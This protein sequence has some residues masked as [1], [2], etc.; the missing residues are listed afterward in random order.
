MAATKFAPGSTVCFLGDSITQ[1][2]GWI[3]RIYEH[4]RRE[5]IGCRIY[6]CG[7]GGDTA[8]HA[9]WRLEETVFCYAPT[10]V[11]VAFGM[12][13]CA[14]GVFKN[15]PLTEKWVIYRRRRQ[16]NC[17]HYLRLI[18]QRCLERNIAV[19]LCTPTLPDALTNLEQ[20]LY[21]GAA[22]ALQEIAVR[23]RALAEELGVGCA[24]ITTPF[25]RQ[26]LRFWKQDKT[27][28]GP[29]RVHPLPEGHEFM[30]KA[31]LQAQGFPMTLP[32][33]WAELE[34]LVAIPHDP[35]EEKR[36]QLELAANANMFVDWNFGYGKRSR[37]SMD[38]AIAQALKTEDREW[39]RQRLENYAANRDQIP[40]RRQALIDHTNTV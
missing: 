28:V 11:V 9:I 34:S 35:W 39:L 31:F 6:N 1:N 16:D 32:Q 12:N 15:E 37:E 40:A 17:I 33:T 14:Y 22:A 4:Y 13:D 19:T 38:A 36:Y 5:G 30:A 26:Q 29:D 2:G 18:A 24:D 10:H 3:R 21:I 8:E 7:V 23:I 27:M 20:T 25:F